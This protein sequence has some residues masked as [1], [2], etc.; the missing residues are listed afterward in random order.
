MSTF[1]IGNK[2]IRTRNSLDGWTKLQVPI[3]FI[4]TIKKIEKYGNQESITF[5]EQ[6]TAGC[7][8]TDFDLY[9]EPTP[10]LDKI[11]AKL[12]AA[13][14]AKAAASKLYDEAFK[15]YEA[16]KEAEIDARTNWL[17]AIKDI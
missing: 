4:G 5:V 8:A 16:A 2:V 1:Q 11:L 7:R 12:V 14:E 10:A 17:K 15:V 6:D 9:E 3:G 13:K